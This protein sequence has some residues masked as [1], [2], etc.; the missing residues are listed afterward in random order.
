MK[1]HDFTAFS[2]GPEGIRTH[3]LTDANESKAVICID[4]QPFPALSA[5][6]R[7]VLW[8]LFPIVTMYPRSI[9]GMR[10]GHGKRNGKAPCLC[11]L[12]IVRNRESVNNFLNCW[13]SK[14]WNAINKDKAA[15]L[16]TRMIPI[17]ILFWVKSGSIQF[18]PY[19]RLSV[20]VMG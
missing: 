14:W 3:D 15:R 16:R 6:I 7:M 10:C 19:Q 18:L 11:L 4:F 13:Q 12:I 8:P 9:C 5:G 2:G 1:S 17:P 20:S